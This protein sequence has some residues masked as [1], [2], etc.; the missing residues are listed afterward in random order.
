MTKNKTPCKEWKPGDPCLLSNLEGVWRCQ[1][2]RRNAPADLVE[3]LNLGY[4][5]TEIKAR[6]CAGPGRTT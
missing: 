5:P 3:Y 4:L 2:C 6:K 1:V